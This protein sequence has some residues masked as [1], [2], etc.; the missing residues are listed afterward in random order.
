MFAGK[1]GTAALDIPTLFFVAVCLAALLG[2]F[3][4]FAWVQER[5]TRALAWWGAAYLI[6][7]SAMA[8]WNTP[9]PLLPISPD[10]AGALMFIACGMIWNGVR[11]FHGRRALFVATFMGAAAW[12]TVSHLPQIGDEPA[13]RAMCGGIVIAIYTFSIARELWRERRKSMFSRTA[14]VVVPLVHGAIFLT[15]IAMKIALPHDSGEGWL[16]ILALETIIYAVGTAFIVLLMVK[17]HQVVMH[18]TAASIDGLTGL[19][20]RRAFLDQAQTLCV[21]QQKAR[22]PV[23]LMM[24]DLDKFKSINDRFGHATGDEALRVFAAA[25]TKSMRTQ[26]VIGRL[27]GEEFAA[28]VAADGDIA[29]KIAERV[30]MNF[31]N[32]GATIAGQV[33][34]ATVSIGTASAPADPAGIDWLLV[35]A[36]TA[37]YL[38]KSGGRNRIE[39]AK[40][41]TDADRRRAEG[42]SAPAQPLSVAIKPQQPALL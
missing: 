31:Q 25:A 1:L 16:Q 22:G 32:A 18:R 34:S 28:I 13:A 36:D 21:R 2:L 30:R 12:L 24:F 11:L 20:N 9:A 8:L 35:R 15:P 42:E 6:G 41:W 29:A 19:L 37:L 3:L 39:A 4:I 10:V 17:D 26:D 27:G 38:A 5:Q 23:T 40:P 33:V 14:A 7:A